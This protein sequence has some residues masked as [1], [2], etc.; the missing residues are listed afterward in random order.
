MSDYL[1]SSRRGFLKAVA[2]AGLA[3]GAPAWPAIAQEK[4]GGDVLAE[5]L[6]R[7]A[8]NLKYEDLPDDVVRLAKRTILDTIGCAFGGYDAGPS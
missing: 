6:A 2:A 8:A 7:Y 5:R 1:A 3:A 4:G